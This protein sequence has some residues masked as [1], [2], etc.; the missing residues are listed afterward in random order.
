MMAPEL[1]EVAEVLRDGGRGGQRVL[2]VLSGGPMTIPEIAK[3]LHCPPREALL[4]VMALRR[5][6]RVVDVPK[7]A[8]DEYYRYR[9]SEGAP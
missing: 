4:W 8:G 2:E 5:Y 9:R 1:R 6:G 3:A 7:S